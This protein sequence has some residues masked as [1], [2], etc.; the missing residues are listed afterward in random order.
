MNTTNTTDFAATIGLDWADRKHDLWI[1]P[2]GQ[3]KAEHRRLDQTPEAL[4]QWVAKLRERFPNQRV[5]VAIETS[6]GPVISALMA[7]DFIVLF[8]VNPKA[9]KDYRAAFCVSGAKDDRT[10]AMLLEELV[11][12]HRDKFNALEPDTELTRKLAG[13]VENRRHLVDERTRLVNQQ[14]STLKTCFPLALDLLEDQM[15]TLLAAEFLA[16]WPSLATLQKETPKALRAF[17][18]KHNSRNAKR[19]E[20]RIQ[21]VPTA[22]PLTTDAAI[23]EPA[24]ALVSARAAMLR[25]LLKAIQHLDKAIAQAMDQHP[26]A[27]IFRSFPGA[28]PALAPRL[29]VAFGTHRQ[30]F[31]SAAEVAQFYGIAPVV[32]QSGHSKTVR[33]RYRC[34]KFGRQ[35]F[36]ENAACALKKEPWARCYYEAH[37]KKHDNKHH[38]ACRALAFKLTRIYFACWRDKK[39]YQ[40]DLYVQALQKNGSPLHKALKTQSTPSCE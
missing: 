29:L 2:V 22:Q 21:A 3:A 32:Q 37:K 9:L 16:R 13:L 31:A 14:H 20:Q 35:S 7:Y 8:P 12:L 26:D 6:R 40:P 25:P 30:R 28:G 18:Y 11:R 19:I 17:F 34:P 39:T 5:A 24:G 27:A 4:H 36:H 15:N 38:P 23:I 33:V 1:S 10:D